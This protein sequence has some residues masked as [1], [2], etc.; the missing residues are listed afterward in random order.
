MQV[1]NAI[2][3]ANLRPIGEAKMDVVADDLNTENAVGRAAVFLDPVALSQAL[4]DGF[5]QR[6]KPRMIF[7]ELLVLGD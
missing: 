1:H 3:T 4:V 6:A 7:A 2:A 5:D